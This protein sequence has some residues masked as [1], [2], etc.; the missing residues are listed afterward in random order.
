M[1]KS[2][3][4]IGLGAAG[5]MASSILGPE[6]FSLDHQKEGGRKLLVTGGGRCNFTTTD[7]LEALVTHYYDKRNFVSPSLYA[8]PPEKIISYFKEL[9]VEAKREGTKVFPKS[10]KSSDIVNALLRKSGRIFFQERISS[11]RKEGDVFHIITDKKIHEAEHVIIATGGITY[12]QT[13]SDGSI[14]PI[15]KSLGHTI[16]PQKGVLTEIMISS[17]PFSKAEGISLSL[18]LKKDKI[19]MKGDAVI[20]ARGI[21][22]PV[23]ENFSHYVEAKDMIEIGF[24][25]IEK[26]YFKK[27]SGKALLK[28]V[29]PLPERL[30]NI[31]LPTLKERRIAEL[32]SKEM[33]EVIRTLR[34]IKVEAYLNGKRAMCTKGGVSVRE[35]DRKSMESKIIPG[36]YFTGE[37]LDV[38]G[39]CGGYNLTWAFASAYSAALDILKKKKLVL[40]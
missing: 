39:E 13:G 31:L 14:N 6:A 33:D 12:P 26:D 37:V 24:L 38:D 8:F 32:S 10:D 2:T 34:G 30:I 25:D 4:I 27:Q 20:T 1:N 21:S 18:T 40:S 22:G 9:G 19:M 17:I 35:V 16:I 15:I 29:L 28:N 5:L 36:L 7:T 23:A 3:A 11:I